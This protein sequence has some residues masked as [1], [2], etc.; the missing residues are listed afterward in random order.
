MT[1]PEHAA[2][3]HLPY[4]REYMDQ[5]LKPRIVKIVEEVRASLA[6]HAWN[7]ILERMAE[8]QNAGGSTDAATIQ[9]MRTLLEQTL[10]LRLGVSLDAEFSDGTAPR[11]QGSETVRRADQV[12]VIDRSPFPDNPLARAVGGLRR[13]GR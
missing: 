10:G 11:P 13:N 6:T 1:S 12:E 4:Y 8:D 5:I 7:E 2:L 3:D 9:K